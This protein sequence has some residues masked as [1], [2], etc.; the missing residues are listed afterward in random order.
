MFRSTLPEAE[1]LS[2]PRAR[3]RSQAA[4]HSRRARRRSIDDIIATIVA[5]APAG[6]LVVIMSN[7]GFGGIHRQ[8]AA[9]LGPS[10]AE[11]PRVPARAGRRLRRHRGVRRA[12]SIRR[13]T[14]RRF[15]WPHALKP[16]G[17]AG[18]RDVVPTYRTRRRLLR[19]APDRLRGVERPSARTR[20]LRRRPCGRAAGPRTP[21]AARACPVCYGGDVGPDL[22]DGRR[23]RGC[24]EADVIALH[25]GRVYRVFML[26][27][28]PG[29]RLPGHRR[30]ARSRRRAVPRRGCRCLP[31]SV[32][33]A[34]AQTGIYPVE[35]PGGWQLI[36]RTPLRPFDLARPDAIPAS[37][38]ATPSQFYRGV[39]CGRAASGCACSAARAADDGAGSR[40]M[41][42][43]G[44]RRVPSPDRWIRWSHR[45]ANALVGNDADAATLE[46]TLVGPELEFDDE[47]CVAVAGRA[48]SLSTS[49]AARQRAE[50]APSSCPRRPGCG[51]ARRLSGARARTWRSP[52]ASMCRGARQPRDAPRRAAWAAST[53]AR[54]RPA[55]V[56]PLGG[57]R[58]AR[59]ALGRSC[60]AHALPEARRPGSRPR[61]ARPAGRSLRRQT[62]SSVL[63]SAPYSAR[64]RLEPDGIPA[65]RA[66]AH[67]HRAEREIISDAT[68]L[69]V[70]A[71]ARVRPAR[72][73]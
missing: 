42:I 36:G 63:Q 25:T 69:G 43:A 68:P 22:A 5:R 49:T 23:V 39:E 61:A 29:F 32:G 48:S 54:W 30:R 45:L 66:R 10:D 21:P 1:R 60:A 40:T 38:R 27:F 62:R 65:G 50:R 73:C 8:A 26:G 6:D 24:R 11:R 19:S 46:V 14:R 58:R 2:V 7:G 28:L 53:A 41:G 67:A 13:S 16:R 33:I 37:G 51:S 4:R 72:S 56:L 31:G 59:A 52:A 15:A 57:R 18:V 9:A 47:R 20:A 44:A 35:T 17:V 34:G 64:A 3:A 70:A 71:G 55:I 12:G